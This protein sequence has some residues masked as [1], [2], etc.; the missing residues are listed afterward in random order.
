MVVLCCLA[1]GSPAGAAQDDAFGAN[2]QTLVNWSTFWPPTAQFPAT[3]P[4]VDPYLSALAAD[5]VGVARTDAPWYWVQPD[6][7][8]QLGD[9]SSWTQL[10]GVVQELAR[11]HLRWQP[12]IDLAPAWAAQAPN[13]PTGCAPA[14]QRYLPPASAAQFAAYAGAL[15]ARYGPGGAFWAANPGLPNLP[16]A[17]YE[18]WNEPNVDAYWNNAPSAAQYVAIYNAARAQIR[19]ADPTAQVLV[20]GI[21]WGGQVHCEPAVTNDA[22]YIE[23]MFAAGGPAWAVDGIA[24]HPY[25]PAALNIVANLR[26]EQQALQVVGRTDVPLE[27]TELGWPAQPADAPSGSDAAGYADDASRAGTVALTS[28]LVMGSDCGVQSYDIY[29]AVERET[30][31]VA[32]DP[33]GVSPYDLVEHWMG[34]FAL[35]ATSGLAPNTLTSSALAAAVA[36][37]EAGDNAGQDVPVCA[38]S[39]TVGRQLPLVLSVAATT[40]AGCFNATV[41]YLGL[42]VSGAELQA[43]EAIQ[44]AG[45]T[46]FGPAFTD[47]DGVVGFCVP[48][49]PRPT[50]TAVVGGGSFDPDVVPRVATSNAVEA[51]GPPGPVV[52]TT[53]T[54]SATTV[55]VAG[56]QMS[57]SET[58]TPSA[59]TTTTSSLSQVAQTPVV[60][61]PPACVLSAV[62]V[63]R[64]DLAALL[65]HGLRTRISLATA[66]RLPGCELSLSLRWHGHVVGTARARL[67]HRGVTAVTLRLTRAGARLLRHQRSGDLQLQVV[68]P[69][70]PVGTGILNERV[71]LSARADG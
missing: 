49:G 48:A 65:R 33:P 50:I 62:S 25:G 17:R 54:S 30:D 18:I 40:Q 41:T 61:P 38:P 15:A 1:A 64:E 26:R 8:S 60:S 35:G 47:P 58:P 53:T 44:A 66:A 31:Q 14:E 11:N 55:S 67:P 20:G 2:V 45:S 69:G 27:Q 3:A 4:P 56:S 19:A 10:D 32:D 57:T 51:S 13:T 34:I 23:A 63:P 71:R 36:R 22:S 7:T 21:V 9:A 29:T 46:S 24:V 37:D 43:T 70:A 5:G 42:P 6:A 68:L 12:V 52:T 39:G 16:V 28:D 59:T